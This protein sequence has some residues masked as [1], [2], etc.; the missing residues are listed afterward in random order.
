MLARLQEPVRA[1]GAQPQ[2]CA[3][4]APRPAAAPKLAAAAPRL[5]AA[6]PE[7]KSLASCTY[8]PAGECIAVL[9]SL[10][11]AP[12]G[13]GIAIAAAG[14]DRCLQAAMRCDTC[15]H[16]GMTGHL[17][18]SLAVCRALL[19]RA[20]PI[21]C[22]HLAWAHLPSSSVHSSPHAAG[23]LP[24]HLPA[25]PL[26]AQ[27]LRLRCRAPPSKCPGAAQPPHL[28]LCA[29]SRAAAAAARAAAAA[30]GLQSR[31]PSPHLA[32]QAAPTQG[33]SQ[34][35]PAA[36]PA[37]S[38]VAVAAQHTSRPPSR[39]GRQEGRARALSHRQHQQQP[40]AAAG[41]RPSLH[42]YAPPAQHSSRLQDSLGMACAIW[43]R[44]QDVISPCLHTPWRF[45]KDDHAGP[46]PAVKAQLVISL[47]CAPPL[48]APPQ[49]VNR[50]L[51]PLF[52]Q[53]SHHRQRPGRR[54]ATS[55]GQVQPGGGSS[56]ALPEITP[57]EEGEAAGAAGRSAGPRAGAELAACA[58]A[59]GPA[60]VVQRALSAALSPTAGAAS[61][62][63]QGAAG[64]A[65]L[66]PQAAAAVAATG[67]SGEGQVGHAERV[68][69]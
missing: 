24:H 19:Q 8:S 42:R 68:P 3:A 23:G 59:A 66:P 15:L 14:D 22:R 28:P 52:G 63:P 61:S 40:A 64:L 36:L 35:L 6:A 44:M 54:T 12:T 4:A 2:P 5:A 16:W 55:P 17:A 1:I 11:Q 41:L 45:T 67:D 10:F 33:P 37:A 49:G 7:L 51:Q 56:S 13:R 57:L 43:P 53:F 62:P 48:P 38:P 25:S 65:S 60:R 18:R 29:R 47:T 58:E 26:K 31:L 21:S 20:S 34:H 30:P 39:R 9:K 27:Q 32:G 46:A 50:N 69:S